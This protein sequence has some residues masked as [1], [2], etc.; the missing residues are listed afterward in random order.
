[1]GTEKHRLCAANTVVDLMGIL[2]VKSKKV[3]TKR[4]NTRVSGYLYTISSASLD[5]EEQG[6]MRRNR[7]GKK[8]AENITQAVERKTKACEALSTVLASKLN[9]CYRSDVLNETIKVIL[10]DAGI[11]KL[12][13]I[14]LAVA[15]AGGSAQSTQGTE[16]F[17]R[18]A[19]KLLSELALFQDCAT[20]IY[21]SEIQFLSKLTHMNP[22]FL[23]DEY[24]MKELS[25]LKKN[26]GRTLHC[27]AVE[28]VESCVHYND[29]HCLITLLLK[30]CDLPYILLSVLT[31]ARDLFVDREHLFPSYIEQL[32]KDQEWMPCLL[33]VLERSLQ[34]VKIYSTILVQQQ[35]DHEHKRLLGL[36]VQVLVHVSK[37][38]QIRA[39]LR[40]ANLVE[41]LKQVIERHGDDRDLLETSLW[42]LR[43]FVPEADAHSI[44]IHTDQQRRREAFLAALETKPLVQRLLQNLPAERIEGEQILTEN[45]EDS[46]PITIPSELRQLVPY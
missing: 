29:M 18:A 36:C 9:Q 21:Q 31:A 26:L 41:L 17:L 11:D 2:L 35:T 6:F 5:L 30:Y 8:G 12:L 28:Q 13:T 39:K 43:S 42:C 14:I 27:H 16:V 24:I 25:A 44:F 19:M 38:A 34:Q 3:F 46:L 10:R 37:P 7:K 23:E 22:A 32:A 20:S 33:G 1:M 40:R 45:A 4:W 15:L